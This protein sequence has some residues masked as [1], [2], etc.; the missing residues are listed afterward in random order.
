MTITAKEFKA[1]NEAV[2]RLVR[3]ELAYDRMLNKPFAEVSKTESERS[4]AE[5]DQARELYALLVQTLTI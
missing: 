2:A 5:R 4:I 3:S 1:L